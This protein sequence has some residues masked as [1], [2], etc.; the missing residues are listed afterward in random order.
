MVHFLLLYIAYTKDDVQLQ[1]DL[2]RRDGMDQTP[3]DML[4]LN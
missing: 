4:V 1:Q 3:L 2:G